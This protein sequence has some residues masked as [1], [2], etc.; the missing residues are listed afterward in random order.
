MS[1]RPPKNVV[2]LGLVSFFNDLSSEMVLS[3]MPAFFVSV[4]K[5]GAGALGLVE[6]IADAAS[7]IIKIYSGRLSDKLQRRRIFLFLGYSLSVATR[8]F[9]LLAGSVAHVAILRVTDRVGKGLRDSPR[10]AVISL[11]TKTEEI[12][13]AFGLH[14]ALDTLGGILGPLIAY[15][16]LAAYPTGFHIVFLT[17][18]AAGI[19]AVLT[20]FFVTDVV[21][22]VNKGELSLSSFAH[23]SSD[24]KRYI[25]SLLFLSIG[26]VP[27]AVLLLKTQ[28]IGLTLASIPLFYLLYNISYAGFSYSAGGV[29]DKLGSKKVLI[30]GYLLLVASYVFLV[31]AE[32]AVLL[33]AGFLVLGLFPAL[34]DGVQ[35][36]FASQLSAEGQRG[37]AFGYV[38]AVSG[39]G[40]LLAGISGGF[41]WQQFGS[42]A[43]L[44]VASLFV[45][46]GLGILVTIRRVTQ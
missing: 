39:I 45:F 35:R 9:Y 31:F 26:S 5:T 8:P 15:L 4:L 38:N 24:F 29:S 16:I 22:K 23:F 19:L 28:S 40:L 21:G 42:G 34:T 17:A 2:L 6:G 30:A 25:L 13:R 1:Y 46:I 10:D 32:G 27:V 3:V 11:S 14:R 7:N 43:A 20:I 12:G 37:G 36:A 41:L 44:F 33:V 18:F